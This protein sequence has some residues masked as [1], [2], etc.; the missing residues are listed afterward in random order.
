MKRNSLII[1]IVLSLFSIVSFAQNNF[2]SQRIDISIE[3]AIVDENWLNVFEKVSP[4]FKDSINSCSV[5]PEIRFIYGHSALIIGKNNLSTDQFY[6]KCDSMNSET[7]NAWK[8]YTS[9]LDSKHNDSP[10]VKYLLADAYARLGLFELA[11]SELDKSLLIN[12]NHVPSLNCR[13]VINWLLF[14]NSHRKVEKYRIGA[15]EDINKAI[16]LKPDYADLYSNRAIFYMRNTGDMDLPQKD[17][18]KALD[19]DSTY[20]L[21]MN[22]YAFS[23]GEEGE[24]N[25]YEDIKSKI[26]KLYPE[27]PF[28][29]FES[30]SK[31][32]K[33]R[34]TAQMSFDFKPG[35]IGIGLS[36]TLDDIMRGGIFTYLK[37]GENLKL[38][39]VGDAIKIITWF[40]YNYPN[41]IFLLKEEF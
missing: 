33:Y 22:S 41:E 30:D 32:Y 21:A 36:G 4:Y 26:L 27:N 7:L 19:I 9:A 3:N 12:R 8:T 2:D 10:A 29:D 25:I 38:S 18:E 34:G 16:A 37:E 11:K 35:G 31:L 28:S 5:K 13:S 40:N 23:F 20:W 1:F 6:C 15:F 24:L 39:E 14:E 17:L